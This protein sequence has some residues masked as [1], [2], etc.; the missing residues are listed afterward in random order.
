MAYWRGLRRQN[1]VSADESARGAGEPG[2][3]GTLGL[4]LHQDPLEQG[5]FHGYL[6]NNPAL[7]VLAI[8]PEGGFSSEE[9]DQFLGEGFNP[10]LMGNTILRTETAALYAAAAVRIILMERTSWI[11]RPR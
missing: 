11:H 7:V 5:T 8:G 1:A 3:G 4:L 2:S 9:A 10:L 6:G